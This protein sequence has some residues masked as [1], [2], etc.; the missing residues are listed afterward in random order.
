MTTGSGGRLS[1]GVNAQFPH[2]HAGFERDAGMAEELP[3][4]RDCD[5]IDRP[6]LAT[7][8]NLLEGEFAKLILVNPQHIK[9]RNRYKTD[10]KDAEWIPGLL[11]GGKLRNNWVPARLLQELRD[12]TRHRLKVVVEDLNRAKPKRPSQAIKGPSATRPASR[13]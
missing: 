11:E 7:P 6:V 8:W 13:S 4:V 5:G 3:R 1:D 12:L 10:S 2:L 9:V